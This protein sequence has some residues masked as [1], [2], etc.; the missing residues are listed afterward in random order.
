VLSGFEFV[1]LIAQLSLTHPQ[2]AC[3]WRL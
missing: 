2:Q 3:N 1:A